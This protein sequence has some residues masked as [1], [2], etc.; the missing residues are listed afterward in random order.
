M[1]LDQ[2]HVHLL[3]IRWCNSGLHQTEPE[4]KIHKGRLLEFNLNANL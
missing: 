4:R 3:S 1:V 2:L